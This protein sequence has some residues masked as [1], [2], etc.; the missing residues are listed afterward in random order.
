MHT[1]THTDSNSNPA[2]RTVTAKHY[3]TQ[4]T[5]QTRRGRPRNRHSAH[6]SFQLVVPPRPPIFF[7][8]HKRIKI[9]AQGH[10]SAKHGLSQTRRRERAQRTW[11]AVW[12]HAFV[13]VYFCAHVCL[14]PISHAVDGWPCNGDL[15]GTSEAR[16]DTSSTACTACSVFRPESQTAA[17]SAACLAAERRAPATRKHTSGSERRGTG[18]GLSHRRFIEGAARHVLRDEVEVTVRRLKGQGCIPSINAGRKNPISG[19]TF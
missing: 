9:S 8:E 5:I 17:V 1:H 2:Q 7:P 12:I 3:Y 4:R 11:I 13:R 18:C 14:C 19:F 10:G 15:H 16:Q 6:N